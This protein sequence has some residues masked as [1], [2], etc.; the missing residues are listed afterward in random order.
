MRM[1][2]MFRFSPALLVATLLLSACGQAAEQ[3]T[4]SE[5]SP[6]PER[7]SVVVGFYPLQFLVNSIAGD[8]VEVTL[9]AAPGVEPH[10]LELTPRQVVA[11]NDADLVLTIPGFQPAID[12]AV[13]NLS[14]QR[15]L[16]VTSGVTLLTRQEDDEHEDEDDHADEHEGQDPHVWLDPN[17]M[18]QMTDVVAERLEQIAGG[19]FSE[20]RDA[21]KAALDDLDSQWRAQT[22]T[23]RSRDLVVSHEAFGYLADAYGFTQRGISGLSPDSEPSPATLRRVTDFVRAAGITTIYYETLVNPAVAQTVAAETGAATAV[24]DP[25]EGLEEGSNDDYLSIM[26]SNLA[27]I[28][29]GQGCTP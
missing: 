3:G 22:A 8:A 17:R 9:L 19:D 20:S 18:A 27:T 24:L 13:A 25:L 12:D 5:P 14:A 10:D 23:C 21:L 29:T 7:P 6:T 16:D 1:I 15:V 2:L 11:L 4:A 28:V 26:R